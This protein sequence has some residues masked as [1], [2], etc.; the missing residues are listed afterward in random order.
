MRMLGPVFVA[1]AIGVAL[2]GCQRGADQAERPGGQETAQGARSQAIQVKGSD[3]MVNLGQAWAET[4]MG[5]HPGASVAV[6]GGGSGTGIAALINGTADIAQASREMK[7][8]EKQQ[9]AARGIEPAEHTVALDALTVAVHPSNPVKRL[10]AAQLSDIY[11]RKVTNWKELGGPDR[12]IVALS[13]DRNSGTHVFFLEHI[14][15][16]GKADGP[17][18]YAPDVLMMVS[19][20]AIAD[21]VASNKDAIGYFGLGYLD[22]QRHQAVAVAAQES[23]EYVEPS[24]ENVASGKYPISRPL[25]L[26]TRKDPGPA[27]QQFLSF[28][29]SPEGQQIVKAQEFVPLAT[30]A[31]RPAGG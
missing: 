23:G 3:T 26:Y 6:T 17:E 25:Y 30:A 9:A 27:V 10:T 7:E 14:V 21:E 20:Q 11:T 28:V 12:R 8:Q 2:T 16:H 4:Y 15:R 13:R 31:K 24:A 5:K 22:R 19:S 1:L 18:Q 29:L